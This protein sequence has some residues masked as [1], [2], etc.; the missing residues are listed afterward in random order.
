MGLVVLKQAVSFTG[1]YEGYS[2]KA[3]SEKKLLRDVFNKGDLFFNSGDLMTRDGDGFFYWSDRVGDTFRWRGENVSTAE[4][5]NVLSRIPGVATVAVYG[6]SVP[7]TDGKAGMAAFILSQTEPTITVEELLREVLS[8]SLMLP[9]YARPFF[10]RVL[11]SVSMT[12]TYKTQKSDLAKESFDPEIV[13]NHI[14]FCSWKSAGEQK[15]KIVPVS[16]EFVQDLRD[17]KI[18]I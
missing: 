1:K 13:K 12:S 10:I 7:H 11:D 5:E 14:Y 6:V 4:I 8:K 3:A 9:I 2:D 15:Y 18:A 17:R 16:H